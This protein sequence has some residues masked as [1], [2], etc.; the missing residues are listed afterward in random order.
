MIIPVNDPQAS[1]FPAGYFVIRSMAAN[2]LLD[3]TAD[4]IEDGTEICL[5]PEKE[6]SIVESFRDPE[7]NNQVFFVD[8]S[9]AL[10]SRSSGHAIDIEED[11]LVLR[12]RRPVSE[13]FPN[14][15]AHPLPR[16]AY[17][18]D[19][20]EITVNFT[21]DPTYPPPSA[22][23]SVAWKSKT[24][25]LASIPMRKPRTIIDDASEFLATSI[26]TPTLSFFSGR[27]AAPHMSP[28]E[29]FSSDIDLKEDEVVEEERGE[30]L[31]VDDSAELG[32]KVRMV[33][34]EGVEKEKEKLDHLLSDQAR[35]RRRWMVVPLRRANAKTGGVSGN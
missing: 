14:A 11:R 28:E 17:S 4:D 31:E 33:V 24:Y 30:E 29:V 7:A 9:G 13:P 23:P 21:H 16:F 20:G 6:T 18:P 3:V 12:H 19:T 32:R 35:N 26:L 27:S 25:L 15:Y 1:G 5:W 10:C 22:S 8:T 34:V 2:R